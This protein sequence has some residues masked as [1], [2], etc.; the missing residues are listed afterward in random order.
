MPRKTQSKGKCAFCET[1]SAKGAMT[2]HLTVCSARKEAIAKAEEKKGRTETLFHLRIQD[3]YAS[4]F[5]LDLEMRGA[6]T[7]ADLDDYLR[8]IW[9]E[10]CGHLSMFTFG[11]W[12]EENEISLKRKAESLFVSG[13]GL[14]HF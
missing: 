4:D 6:A 12:G 3:R 7:L 11:G 10:C 9:L 8:A 5:W 13:L 2:R 14:F 1:V